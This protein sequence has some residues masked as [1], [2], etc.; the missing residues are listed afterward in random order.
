MMPAACPREA[1]VL[2]A[3]NDSASYVGPSFSSGDSQTYV[4]P[5]FSSGDSQTYVGPSFSSG[6][7]QTY[8]G[9]SFSSGTIIDVTCFVSRALCFS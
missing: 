5:S 6:D 3:L 4:G 8:V 2:A 1:E 7:S 9:P